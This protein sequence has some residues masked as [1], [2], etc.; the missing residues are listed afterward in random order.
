MSLIIALFPH[1]ILLF[2]FYV[3]TGDHKAATQYFMK[4]HELEPRHITSL[5]SAADSYKHLRNFTT[6]ETLLKE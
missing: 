2:R 5:V 1:N 4:A 6:A 3:L